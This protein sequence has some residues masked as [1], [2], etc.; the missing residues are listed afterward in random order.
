MVSNFE[1]IDGIKFLNPSNDMV[2]RSIRDGHWEDNSRRIW[3]ALCHALPINSAIVDVGA[4]TGYYSLVAAKSRPDCSIIAF[5]PHPTIFQALNE[6]IVINEFSN[7]QTVQGALS[8]TSGKTSFNITN[9][10][11]LPS[12]SSLIDIGKPIKQTI[13]VETFT[14]DSCIHGQIDLLKIDVEGAEIKVLRGLETKLKQFKPFCLIELLTDDVLH[15]CANFMGS[16]GYSFV[17]IN[18]RG[19]N[20]PFNAQDRNYLFSPYKLPAL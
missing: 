9:T 13:D 17:R 1:I 8:D 2:V 4:Y 5:E 11:K 14:G 18:E 20:S 7:I 3:S 16:L 15:Q 19:D 10:I 6:N 12:G